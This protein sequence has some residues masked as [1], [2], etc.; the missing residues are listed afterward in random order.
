MATEAIMQY[1]IVEGAFD[2]FILE[3]ILP[4]EIVSQTKI[5]TGNG[6]NIALSKARSLLVSSELPVSLI[7]DSNTTDRT[8]IEEKKDFI[9]QSLRQ[10]STPEHFHIFLAVP[11]IEVIFFSNR[12]VVEELRGGKISDQQLEL[13]H[14]NPKQELL[15]MLHTENL[16]KSFRKLLTPTLIEKLRKTEFVQNIIKSCRVTANAV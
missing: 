6:Y 14:Y 16:Q 10:L 3:R 9:M 8:S 1:F 5:I 13:A 7:V 15:K 2:K 11:E 12:E 4:E